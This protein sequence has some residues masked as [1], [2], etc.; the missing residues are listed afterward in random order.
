MLVLGVAWPACGGGNWLLGWQSANMFMVS[1]FVDKNGPQK[2]AYQ[3]AFTG[4]GH[5][6]WARV[7]S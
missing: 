4:L 1:N 3:R 7:C 6:K 5:E 2:M